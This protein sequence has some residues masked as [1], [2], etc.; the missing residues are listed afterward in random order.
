M[1]R[2][3]DYLQN[4]MWIPALKDWSLEDSTEAAQQGWN[5]YAG[6]PH[7][8]YSF[9]DPPFQVWRDDLTRQL[10]DD[11]A[12]HALLRQ[13][14]TINDPLGLKARSFLEQHS[15]AEHDRIFLKER[16]SGNVLMFVRKK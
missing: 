16:P 10:D 13:L 3:S 5:I 11:E 8:P 14:V 1:K 7:Q 4:P 15:K 2:P 9:A 6:A 12:P